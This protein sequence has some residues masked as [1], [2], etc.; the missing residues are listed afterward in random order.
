MDTIKAVMLYT[1]KQH[2]RT[3]VYLIVV[4]FGLILVLGAM[5]VSS[6]AVEYRIRMMLNMGL[7]GIEFLALI[8]VIFATVNMVLEEMDS[9]SIYLILTHP[10]K[11][12]HYLLGRYFGTLIAV[13]LAMLIMSFLH[14]LSL[15]IVGWGWENAYLISIVLSFIKIMVMSSIALLFSLFSTSA[16]TS[17]VFTIFLWLMGHF[18]EELKF[19]GEKATNIFI[20]IVIWVLYNITP[21]LSYFNYRDFWSAAN[22]PGIMWFVWMVLY[23]FFYITI[24]TTISNF[25]FS[26]KEF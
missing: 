23:S 14:L 17:M 26:Q 7:G 10:I 22:A 15:F 3:K 25:L 8:A 5:V 4:L 20:K 9:R 21:N 16:P 2:I 19:M 6:L 13:G 12:A 1:V 18:S 11:K 24:C